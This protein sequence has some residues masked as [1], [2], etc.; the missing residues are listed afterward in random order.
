MPFSRRRSTIGP[1]VD[2]TGACAVASGDRERAAAPRVAASQRG[3]GMVMRSCLLPSSRATARQNPGGAPSTR[4][5]DRA[6]STSITS[7]PA[8]C[9]WTWPPHWQTHWQASDSTG[10]P[11]G[12][13]MATI[14]EPGVHGSRRR[15]QARLGGEHPGRRCGGRRHQR[16]QGR[17]AHAE[18]GNVDH[19]LHVLDRRRGGGPSVGLVRGKDG[20]LR[21]RRAHRAGE[22]RSIYDELRHRVS[23]RQSGGRCPTTD[24]FPTVTPH[25]EPGRAQGDVWRRGPR[26]GRP[27]GGLPVQPPARTRAPRLRRHPSA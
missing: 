12:P 11:A 2:W 20:E 5:K 6:Q 25:Q 14:A 7:C 8:S 27:Y 26:W 23:N 16:V 10:G 22:S 18:G 9:T 4:S 17:G 19:R 15:G 13:T 3:R 1:I 21:G 24:H